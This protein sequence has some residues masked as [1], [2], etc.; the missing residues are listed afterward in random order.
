MR[1]CHGWS[2]FGRTLFAH[3]LAL[4]CVAVPRVGAAQEQSQT[5][6]LASGLTI[7]RKPFA[8]TVGS[9]FHVTGAVGFNFGERFA[10]R[11]EA[12]YQQLGARSSPARDHQMVGLGSAAELNLLGGT[13][14]YLVGGYGFYQ[15]L[16]SGTVPASSWEGGYNVGGGVRLFFPRVSLFG[17]VRLHRVRGEG[18]PAMVPFSVGIRI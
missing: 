12:M 11:M 18:R 5:V 10:L 1:N 3:G 6:S 15:T 9:G 4:A 17:E 8:D 2:T 16:K 14:P 13:G 7:A